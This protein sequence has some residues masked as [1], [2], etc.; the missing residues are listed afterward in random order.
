MLNFSF[1]T[2]QFKPTYIK[3][4]YVFVLMMQTEKHSVNTQCF[5]HNIRCS[6]TDEDHSAIISNH[7]QGAVWCQVKKAQCVILYSVCNVSLPPLLLQA[8]SL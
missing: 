5:F 7:Q 1:K 6:T 3:A 8:C 2:T 4:S